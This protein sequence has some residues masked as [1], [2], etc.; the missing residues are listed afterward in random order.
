MACNPDN[1]DELYGYVV[2]EFLSDIVVIHWVYCKQEHRRKGFGGQLVKKVLA[3]S[4]LPVHYSHYT[5]FLRKINPKIKLT[6]NPYAA[7]GE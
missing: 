4:T 5:R 2:A 6:Y 7:F 1:E 3:D